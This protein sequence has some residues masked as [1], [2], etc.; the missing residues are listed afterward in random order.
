MT[1]LV[2]DADLA[3]SLIEERRRKGLDRYDEVWDG[4]YFV[5]SMPNVE[6][7]EIATGIGRHIGGPVVDELGGRVFVGVNVS[8]RGAGWIR[9]FRCPD[10]AVYL[11]EN[12]ARQYPTHWCGGPDSGIEIVSHG[13]RSRDKLDFYAAVNTRELLL[14]DRD[15]W[16]LELYRRQRGKMKLI[17]RVTRSSTRPMESVVLPLSWRLISGDPRPKIEITH[18]DGRRWVV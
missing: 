17:G 8:D 1:T 5:T 6:H 2:Q 18:E 7:Q 15:P 3:E 14:I 11:P 13:D 12:P 10:V 4:V 16:A 9:N